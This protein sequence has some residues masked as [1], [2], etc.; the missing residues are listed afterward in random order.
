VILRPLSL[1]EDLMIAYLMNAV[2]YISFLS[3]SS[4][5]DKA[6]AMLAVMILADTLV[7]EFN[8]QY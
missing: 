5:A 8:V 4:T 1:F 3:F 2:F 6:S 7:P